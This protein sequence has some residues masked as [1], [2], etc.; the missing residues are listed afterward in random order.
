MGMEAE[1][2]K[3]FL[4]QGPWALL[5]V[6]SYYTWKKE[7]REREKE[8]RDRETKLLETLNAFSEKYDILHAGIQE[9]K[10]R[11]DRDVA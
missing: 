9:I 3:Y 2:W 1:V 10:K 8:S 11:L 4:T 5:F 6:W 7:A